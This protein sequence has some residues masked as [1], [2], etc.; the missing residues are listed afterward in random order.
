MCSSYRKS[1][2]RQD[3]AFESRASCGKIILSIIIGLFRRRQHP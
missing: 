1:V 3:L 2:S